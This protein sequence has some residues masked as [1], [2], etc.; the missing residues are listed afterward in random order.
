[1]PQVPVPQA[2]CK[3][4]IFLEYDF[5]DSESK[6]L[7]PS[8]ILKIDT[9]SQARSFPNLLIVPFWY[10]EGYTF[11]DIISLFS[12]CNGFYFMSPISFL[13]LLRPG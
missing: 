9:L 2:Y 11:L 13:S 3:F 1:M 8:L 12:I 7:C 4:L 10:F 6:Y 5:P